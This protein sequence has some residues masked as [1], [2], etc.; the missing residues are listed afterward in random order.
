[1]TLVERVNQDL[2]AAM[3]ARDAKRTGTLRLI[4]AAILEE[5]KSGRGEPDDA[6]VVRLLR[7][8]VKQR[9][10]A[11]SQYDAGGRPDLA[12]AERDEIIVVNGYL[13]QLADEATTLAWVREAIAASGAR[14]RRELGRV[15]GPL[16]KA[17]R[18]ELDAAL[19]RTL[20]EA[21]LPE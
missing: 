14:S 15:M 18:E 19:A 4:R 12:E 21:E 11:A 20:I 10:D 1:M 8:M 16:M 5:S 6:A 2:H 9:E 3:K 17:H 13:P 7:Q